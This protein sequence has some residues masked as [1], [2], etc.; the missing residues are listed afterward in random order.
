MAELG[1][2]G[3]K[4][5]FLANFNTLQALPKKKK[6]TDA[7]KGTVRLPYQR[8]GPVR[9]FIPEWKKEFKWL[10]DNSKRDDLQYL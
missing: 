7:K 6:K 1:S 5:S 9:K 3:N 10:E 8:T 4:K 2:D